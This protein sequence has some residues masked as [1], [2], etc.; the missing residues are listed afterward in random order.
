MK[1]DLSGSP[2]VSV[3]MAVYNGADFIAESI[4]SVVAQ[5]YARLE[6]IIVDDGSNDSTLLIA[7]QW[8]KND[9]RVR[10]LKQPHLGHAQALN[11]GIS[12]A[13]GAFIARI[14]HDDLWRTRKLEIQLPF[15]QQREVDVCGSWVRRFGAATG[16]IRFA[17]SHEA[18]RYETL[19]TCPILDS[20]TLFRGDLLR[21]HPYPPEAI[22][23]QELTQC[24]RLLPTFRFANLARYLCDYR[25]HRGQK[26]RR[27]P[28]MILYRHRQLGRQ[29]FITMYPGASA[30]EIAI[31]ER[32]RTTAK[33]PLN[34]AELT[35][36]GRLFARYLHPEDQEAKHR[37]RR[38]W[39]ALCRFGCLHGM[40][41]A[42]IYDDT[43]AQLW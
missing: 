12:A 24:V 22:V 8:M 36:A 26:T 19:F 31:F 1:P 17:Q 42:D 29:H 35:D 41:K 43:L 14:D 20:A 9:R 33:A 13:D 40:A 28:G 6:L 5:S 30:E 15:M 18:I 23:R 11:A 16:V 4:A 21:A 2:L 32:I 39:R 10:V 27:F 37:M 34:R 25:A 3:V 38:R 7:E